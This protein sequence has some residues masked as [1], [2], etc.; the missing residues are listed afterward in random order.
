MAGPFRITFMFTHPK[1]G[2]SETFYANVATYAGARGLALILAQDR[3][4]LLAPPS[5]MTIIRI[6]DTSTLRAAALVKPSYTP[7]LA[8]SDS[9]V[10]WNNA[11]YGLY[12]TPQTVN[13][14]LSLRGIPDALFDDTV[15][16]AKWSKIAD[17]TFFKTLEDPLNT[18]SIRVLTQP[19]PLAG[20]VTS[21]SQDPV[22]SN[23][24]LV[25]QNNGLV[26]GDYVIIYG[27]PKLCPPLRRS[28]V[29]TA[30]AQG[31]SIAGSLPANFKY[32]G[33]ATWRKLTFSMNQI[34]GHEFE[35][36]SKRNVGRP[37]GLSRGRR[38]A[39]RR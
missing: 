27:L 29:L 24:V 18:F 12:G 39:C 13:R 25:E 14:R 36:I 11:L 35:R 28:R 15:A 26:A 23:K 7:Y 38:P 17:D 4:G 10:P 20:T 3:G 8:G 6:S 30:D 37:F 16:L 9:D 2:W 34:T 5:Q 32:N 22:D 33:G 21:F 31:F 19:A 1:G